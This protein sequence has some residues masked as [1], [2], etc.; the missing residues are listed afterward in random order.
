MMKIIGKKIFSIFCS[1]FCLFKP[2]LMS[3]VLMSHKIDHIAVVC[4]P[5]IDIFLV[6]VHY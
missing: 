6:S 2:V 5:G 3:V 4:L 1:I